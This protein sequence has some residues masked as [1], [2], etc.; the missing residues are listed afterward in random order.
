MIVSPGR[1]I[2][3]IEANRVVED[4]KPPDVVLFGVDDVQ[5]CCFA[6]AFGVDDPLR[7]SQQQAVLRAGGERRFPTPDLAAFRRRAG[8]S[9][10][11]SRDRVVPAFQLHQ[12]QPALEMRIAQITVHLERAIELRQRIL[13][14]IVLK[15]VNAV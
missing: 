6:C 2:G 10:F 11:E 7:S 15:K 4:F 8:Q 13:D 14:Q 9:A 1:L 12:R 3:R 5:H